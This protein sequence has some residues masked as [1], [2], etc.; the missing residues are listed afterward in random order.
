MGFSKA[1]KHAL[2]DNDMTPSELARSTGFS[3]QYIANLLNGNRRWNE[4]SMLKVCGVLGLEIAV[5]Q[6]KE[7][8]AA[9]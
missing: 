2:V 9:P 6:K 3:V 7:E 4:E 5:V 8:A 1:I